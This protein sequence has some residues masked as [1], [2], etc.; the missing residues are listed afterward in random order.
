MPIRVSDIPPAAN[1]TR[2]RACDGLL[3]VVD[4]GDGEARP[5]H[6][7]EHPGLYRYQCWLCNPVRYERLNN[8]RN[9]TA[10]GIT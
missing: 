9:P 8:D 10:N 7:W 4:A 5:A 1:P 6:K 2:C 3:F